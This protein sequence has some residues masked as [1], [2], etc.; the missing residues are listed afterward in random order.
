REAAEKCN[1]S[2]SKYEN[3]I[4]PPKHRAAFFASTQ[5]RKIILMGILPPQ[6]DNVDDGL[7]LPHQVRVAGRADPLPVHLNPGV[8]ESPVMVELAALA[9]PLRVVSACYHGRAE[10]GRAHV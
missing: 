3:P 4:Q 5:A 6:L 1:E 8:G 9:F 10:I 7:L 2:S